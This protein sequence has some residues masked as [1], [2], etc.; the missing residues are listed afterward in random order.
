MDPLL[1]DLLALEVRVAQ[2]FRL[3]AEKVLK[4]PPESAPEASAWS[5]YGLNFPAYL[6][7][8]LYRTPHPNNPL[9]GVTLELMLTRL[10]ERLG[11]E[12]MGKRVAIQCFKKDPSI[13][14]SLVFL[15]RT[16]WARAEVEKLYLKQKF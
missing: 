11:W 12:R 4:A 13:K 7:A 3:E 9:H 2:A 14:S 10:Q 5:D 1:E 16:P 8:H 6:F 15:R